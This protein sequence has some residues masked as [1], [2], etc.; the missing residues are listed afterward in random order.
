[1]CLMDVWWNDR[2]LCSDLESSN[3]NKHKKRVVCLEFQ[4]EMEGA[5]HIMIWKQVAAKHKKT[6]NEEKGTNKNT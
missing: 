1:M 6:A 5:L 3:W 4:V 2:F